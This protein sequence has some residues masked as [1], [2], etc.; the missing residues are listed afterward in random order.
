MCVSLSLAYLGEAG[1]LKQAWPVLLLPLT[2]SYLNWVVIPLEET[3]LTE[4]F[5][6]VYLNYKARVRRW[7]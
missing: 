3:R 5:G 7:F 1:L 4:V 6:E 2:L